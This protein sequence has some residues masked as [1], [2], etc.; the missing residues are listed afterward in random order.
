MGILLKSW[1]EIAAV[2]SGNH[3]YAADDIDSCAIQINCCRWG[4]FVN[5]IPMI[6]Y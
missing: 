1:L 6:L 4:Q 3:T 2:K 5:Y